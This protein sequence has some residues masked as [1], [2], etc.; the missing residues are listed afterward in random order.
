MQTPVTVDDLYNECLWDGVMY[1]TKE[2]LC[3]G[4][5][6]RCAVRD[7]YNEV[8]RITKDFGG[9]STSFIK[10]FDYVL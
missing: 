5:C 7:L 10:G 4:S 3:P 2:L 9:P 6:G 1:T 8:I